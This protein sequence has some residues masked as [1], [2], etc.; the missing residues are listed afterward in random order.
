VENNRAFADQADDEFEFRTNVTFLHS[1]RWREP[2]LSG[3]IEHSGLVSGRD[4][5]RK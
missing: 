4:G 5:R 1:D 2:G 3:G